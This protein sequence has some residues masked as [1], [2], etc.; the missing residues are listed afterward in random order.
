MEKLTL[1]TRCV[2]RAI[3]LSDSC[4]PTEVCFALEM[5]LDEIDE[6]LSYQFTFSDVEGAILEYERD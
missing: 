1:L 5:I 6:N 2:R 3:L 4:C